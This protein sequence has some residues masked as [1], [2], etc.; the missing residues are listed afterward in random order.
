MIS[1]PQ[2]RGHVSGCFDTRYIRAG[3]FVSKACSGSKGNLALESR[4]CYDMLSTMSRKYL[5]SGTKTSFSRSSST[6]AA[7]NFKRTRSAF[8]DRSF[9]RFLA[10]SPKHFQIL[11]PSSR[12]G[13]I[14]SEIRK[15][16]A[17]NGIFRN[18]SASL[19]RLFRRS[20]R[21]AQSGYSW[22]H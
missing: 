17:M 22:T 2:H 6:V 1:N 14:I 3:L 11:W 7:M 5:L 10:K 16:S 9:I 4:L 21:V 15:K 8:F 13:I 20:Y 19:R 18:C 12:I